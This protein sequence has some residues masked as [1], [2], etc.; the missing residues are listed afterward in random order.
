LQ[1]QLLRYIFAA[2]SENA[3]I[4]KTI[5][6]LLMKKLLFVLLLTSSFVQAQTIREFRQ[7]YLDKQITNAA[8]LS[9]QNGLLVSYSPGRT[10]QKNFFT[11]EYL[12]SYQYLLSGTFS[13]PES[14]HHFGAYVF[15]QKELDNIVMLN[16]AHRKSLGNEASFSIGLNAG[17]YTSLGAAKNMGSF[18]RAGLGM[19]IQKRENYLAISYP[20]LMKSAKKDIYTK[21]EPT[22]FIVQGGVS[23][24]VDQNLKIKP[25]IYMQIGTNETYFQL[26]RAKEFVALDL[27]LNF[28]E[29]IQINGAAGF[30]NFRV[31]TTRLQRFGLSIKPTTKITFGYQREMQSNFAN[32][33]FNYH[34]IWLKYAF[35]NGTK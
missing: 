23:V 21:I 34:S 26:T 13:K 11:N 18:I 1:I 31:R 3:E 27:A 29:F 33:E 9:N 35:D 7:W 22:A 2:N 25:S 32:Y 5:T 20:V 4:I 28:R 10:I 19:A 8:L 16:Y 17:V 15:G 30:N 24:P 14:R 12:N 6:L